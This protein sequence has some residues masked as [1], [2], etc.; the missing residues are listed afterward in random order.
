MEN[1]DKVVAKGEGIEITQ[2]MMDKLHAGGTVKLPNGS[3]LTF[4][5]EEQDELEE[6]FIHKMKYKAGIIK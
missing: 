2:A 4:V 3:T 5:K 1:K 6:Q